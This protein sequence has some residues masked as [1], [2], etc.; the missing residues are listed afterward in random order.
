[1][2]YLSFDDD[3]ASEGQVGSFMCFILLLDFLSAPQDQTLFYVNEEMFKFIHWFFANLNVPVL[4]ND[5]L[6]GFG[7]NVEF[8]EGRIVFANKKIEIAFYKKL[9]RKLFLRFLETSKPACMVTGDQSFFEAISMKKIVIYDVL[10]YKIDLARHHLFFL[11]SIKR[12]GIT[13]DEEIY[14]AD[15]V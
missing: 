13:R 4:E 8:R 6:R 12:G 15:L 3:V 14:L 5:I 11:A 9:P 10:H 1:M 2:A 7:E